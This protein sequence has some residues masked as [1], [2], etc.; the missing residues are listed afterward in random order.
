M[1]GLGE[2]EEE[3]QGV[4]LEADFHM[5]TILAYLGFLTVSGFSSVA[6]NTLLFIIQA[7]EVL[8]SNI[9]YTRVARLQLLTQQQSPGVCIFGVGERWGCH[10]V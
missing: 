7:R 2:E 6:L 4:M 8:C 1:R 9:L 10:V 5:W 3:A